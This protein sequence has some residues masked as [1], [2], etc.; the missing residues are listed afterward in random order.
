[1]LLALSV[2]GARPLDLM[3]FEYEIPGLVLH[4]ETPKESVLCLVLPTNPLKNQFCFCCRL[5][6]CNGRQIIFGHYD[7]TI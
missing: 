5:S 4:S 2:D 3:T 7:N 1:M 6:R